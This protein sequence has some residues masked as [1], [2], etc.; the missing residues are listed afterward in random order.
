M[1]LAENLAARN[2]HTALIVGHLP[3]DTAPYGTL[4]RD[5]TE[6]AFGRV[7]KQVGLPTYT[8]CEAA[9]TQVLVE[10]GLDDGVALLQRFGIQK[11]SDLFMGMYANFHSYART[12]IDFGVSPVW[13]WETVADIKDEQRDR[14]LLWHNDSDCLFEIRGKLSGELDD[15]SVVDVSGEPTFEKQWISQSKG[16][17]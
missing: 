13:A 1:S 9:M 17:L 3:G 12:V 6:A 16:E 14:W 15:G 2:R 7:Y 5:P 10:R 4:D 11:M 8:D